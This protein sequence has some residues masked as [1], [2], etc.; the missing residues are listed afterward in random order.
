[1]SDNRGPKSEHK[2]N[3][4]SFL[5]HL[6]VL[7]WILMRIVIVLTVFATVV[8]IYREFVFQEIIFA[9]QRMDFVTYV[10]F[11]KLSE[12]LHFH[13]PQIFDAKALC[14]DPIDPFFL[15]GKMTGKFMTAMLVSIIGGAIIAFP[16]IIW[17]FWR[18]VSPALYPK[19]QKNAR[20]L[21][22]FSS[23]LFLGGIL[24]GYFIIN[25]LSVHFLIGFD[26]GVDNVKEL[27]PINSFMGIV[28][29]TTLA[30]GVMFELPVMV[31]FLSKAGLVTPEGMRKYRKH[32]FVATL[33]VSAIITPPDVFSQVLVSIPIVILYEMSIFISKYVNKK[34][35]KI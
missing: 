33:L 12:I 5:E 11:C 15:P 4:L 26:M 2:Q 8:F 25:P 35:S 22:F 28:A 23:V 29:S 13:L 27:Y 9:S 18:F 31:Y 1:M 30:T 20:G 6:E 14:F 17:E 34:A 24:F 3:Q 10:Q 21:V 32:A 16:Y 7:R 19:E